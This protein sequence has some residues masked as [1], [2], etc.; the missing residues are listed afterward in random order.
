MKRTLEQ[1]FWNNIE[2]TKDCWFWID[3][4]NKEGYG[5]LV[6]EGR[7]WKAHRASWIIHSKET[8]IEGMCVCHKCDI[9][10]CVNP[11]HLWLGT[12]K[13]NNTDRKKKGKICNWN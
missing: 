10:S 4:K 5:M 1:V 2:Y 8:I 13:D 7:L 6:W 9:P 3:S 11:S 12:F